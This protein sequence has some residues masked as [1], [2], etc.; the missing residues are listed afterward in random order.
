MTAKELIEYL[1][2]FDENAEVHIPIV[3]NKKSII[4]NIDDVIYI[5]DEAVNY[6]CI[7]IVTT[8]CDE[9]IN[10]EDDDAVVDQTLVAGT[11]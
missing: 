2:E 4:H 1:Q 6:P 9:I 8:S 7:I 10:E 11:T 3:N 5:K